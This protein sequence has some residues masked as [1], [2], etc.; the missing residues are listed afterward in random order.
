MDDIKIIE[1]HLR[2]HLGY[3]PYYSMKRDYILEYSWEHWAV[4]EILTRLRI[5]S[6]EDPL[7]VIQGF[8]DD[9]E[10]FIKRSKSTRAKILFTTALSI[11]KGVE[12]LL[13]AKKE[14]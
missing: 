6:H 1:C 9:M 2:D 3:P 13:R 10:N 5:H 12:D 11:G 7:Y 14:V 4:Q 8:N